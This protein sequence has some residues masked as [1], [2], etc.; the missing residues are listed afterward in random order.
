[1]ITIVADEGKG[2][3]GQELF[4]QLVLKGEKSEYVSLEGV[5]VKPCVGCEGCTYKTYGKCITRDDGDWIFPKLMKADVLLFVTPI[6]FGSY[7]F[8]I[9][10]VVDKFGLI[11]DR[12]YF[13]EKGEI[14]KGGMIGKQFVFYAVALMDGCIDEEIEVFKKLHHEN[15]LITRGRGKAFIVDALP[16]LEVKNNILKEVMGT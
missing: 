13:M 7:S 1:M 6:T 2:K 16:S 9:K 12:H 15:L 14:V 11:M 4:E 10:R 3:I 8:K 5:E